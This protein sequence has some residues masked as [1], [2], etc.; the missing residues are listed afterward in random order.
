MQYLR[1]ATN[2]TDLKYREAIDREKGKIWD[3][4]RNE[5]EISPLSL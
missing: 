5:T 2:E 3:S 4:L 1:E